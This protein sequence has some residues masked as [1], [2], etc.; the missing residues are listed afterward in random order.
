MVLGA[1]D[2]KGK[3]GDDADCGSSQADGRLRAYFRLSHSSTSSAVNAMERSSPSV[4]ASG[5]KA[6]A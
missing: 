5:S 4:E 3:I 2:S 1:K 6:S